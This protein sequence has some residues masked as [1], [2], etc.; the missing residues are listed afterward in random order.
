MEALRDTFREQVNP[1]HRDCSDVKSCF[2]GFR[3]WYA[4]GRARTQPVVPDP[5]DVAQFHAD[6]NRLVFGNA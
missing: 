6:A 3:N 2:S 4:H 1:L 5:E